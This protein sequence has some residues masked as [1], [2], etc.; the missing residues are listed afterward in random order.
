VSPT[1]CKSYA[2]KGEVVMA[3]ADG[4]PPWVPVLFEVTADCREREHDMAHGRIGGPFTSVH[5]GRIR[6]CGRIYLLLRQLRELLREAD[7]E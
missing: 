3:P 4:D 1:G 5:F 6:P 7:Y 2:R